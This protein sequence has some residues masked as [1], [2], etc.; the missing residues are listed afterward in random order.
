[1]APLPQ[2]ESLPEPQVSDDTQLH[3]EMVPEGPKYSAVGTIRVTENAL[4]AAH[5]RGDALV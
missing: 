4:R 3:A 1:M 5:Q 2:W